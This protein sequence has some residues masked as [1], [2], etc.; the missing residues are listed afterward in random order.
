MDLN[1]KQRLIGIFV[2]IAIALIA[3]PSLFEFT[4]KKSSDHHLSQN[5]PIEPHTPEVAISNTNEDEIDLTELDEFE[6]N[7]GQKAPAPDNEEI[8]KPEVPAKAAIVEAKLDTT[9]LDIPPTPKSNP[10]IAANDEL[11]IPKPHKVEAVKPETLKPQETENP[12][13]KLTPKHET[14]KPKILRSD[15]IATLKTKKIL[16]AKHTKPKN[17]SASETH[18]H[19]TSKTKLLKLQKP[20]IIVEQKSTLK[21]PETW[22]LQLGSFS[23][24]E[25]ATKLINALRKKGLSAYTVDTYGQKKTSTRVYVGP[26]TDKLKADKLVRQISEEFHINAI[27]VRNQV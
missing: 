7:S 25:N 20:N 21:K 24:K 11:I 26:C 12:K 9:Q 10:K 8:N 6:L 27:V 23:N 22:T 1:K 18:K 3:I 2:L 14:P 17:P 15:E 4:Y 13:P 16:S 19:P 5:I